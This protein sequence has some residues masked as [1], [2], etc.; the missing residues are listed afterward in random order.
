MS[1]I[2]GLI[3]YPPIANL[4][5]LIDSIRSD[6][7]YVLNIRS[8]RLPTIA[9]LAIL[10]TLSCDIEFV[11]IHVLRQIVVRPRHLWSSSVP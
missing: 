10:A 11:M 9:T 5:T 8:H 2:S 1:T 6:Q 7:N 3:A 4:A